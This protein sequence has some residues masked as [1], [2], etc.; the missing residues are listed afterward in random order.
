M[1][2]Q[3]TESF[4]PPAQSVSSYSANYSWRP[5]GTTGVA[6]MG[7][8]NQF[9]K[10]AD[11]GGCD[12]ASAN[13][14]SSFKQ[15]KDESGPHSPL[16]KAKE[17]RKKPT[18]A[19]ST[20]QGFSYGGIGF[21]NTTTSA[22]NNLASIVKNK[23]IFEKA[24]QR[25]TTVDWYSKLQESKNAFFK[26]GQACLPSLTGEMADPSGVFDQMISAKKEAKEMT[27]KK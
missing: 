4:K 25:E 19:N 16:G 9:T 14:G 18:V 21:S 5:G 27:S 7:T 20:M 12:L 6:S 11:L 26:T 10:N 15:G 24:Q 23:D 13:F 1:L 22:E 3:L 2:K 17:I 8:Y